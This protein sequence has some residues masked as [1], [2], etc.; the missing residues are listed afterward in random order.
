M[1][2]L[3]ERFRERVNLNGPVPPHC[4]DIGPCAIW[5]GGRWTVGYGKIRSHNRELLAHRVSWEYHFNAIPQGLCV[6][7]RCDNPL[8]VRASHLFLGTRADNMADKMRKGRQPTKL[9]SLQVCEIRAALNA[10]EAQRSI[11]K[12]F[13][14][15]Q[16]TVGFIGRKETWRALA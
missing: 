15:S 13:A 3:A 8:C 5:T 12:R 1:R 14:V 7:H 4:P 10:G 2:S 16:G 11:A 9:T 6:L